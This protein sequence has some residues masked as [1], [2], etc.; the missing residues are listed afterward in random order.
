VSFSEGNFLNRVS[1]LVTGDGFL[2]EKQIPLTACVATGAS[3][4]ALSSN[5]I[6]ITLDADNE[7]IT[8]PVTV[9][10]DYDESKDA[11]AVVLTALL[12][13]GDMSAETNTIALDLDQVI[14]ARL[15]ES[16]VDD[17][18]SSVTSDS[19]SVD[20][21]AI[22]DYVFDLSGLS[23]EVGDVLSVE[24]DAQET[25]T[26][27]ATVYAAKI[28]YRSDLAAFNEGERSNSNMANN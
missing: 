7:S 27:V 14:R 6:V 13:T 2:R 22:A 23:L 18:S 19:Q 25:G 3:A 17:L 24:I 16:A 10:L 9:P 4:A 1:G 26:A 5:T 28:L 20:D 15:G 8:V 11:L 21:E 12:T